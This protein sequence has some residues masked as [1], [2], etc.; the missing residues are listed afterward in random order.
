M[1]P[2]GCRSLLYTTAAENQ[3]LLVRLALEINSAM[4]LPKLW[5]LIVHDGKLYVKSGGDIQ[6]KFGPIVKVQT[7]R[8]K[9]TSIKVSVRACLT[10]G[11]D[12]TS[13]VCRMHECLVYLGLTIHALYNAF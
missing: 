1:L 2:P 12:F 13:K 7:H 3:Q 5:S 4:P 11:H 8:D 10:A 9:P 6:F